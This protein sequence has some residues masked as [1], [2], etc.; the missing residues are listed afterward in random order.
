MITELDMLV[1]QEEDIITDW[2]GEETE[3]LLASIESLAEA[4]ESI[5]SE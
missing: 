1:E 5:Y 4:F 2:L 3:M